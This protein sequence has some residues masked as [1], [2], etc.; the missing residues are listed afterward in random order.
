[1][2]DTKHLNRALRAQAAPCGRVYVPQVEARRTWFE[3]LVPTWSAVG[4]VGTTAGGMSEPVAFHADGCMFHAMRPR[5]FFDL[6]FWAFDRQP[7]ERAGGLE[8]RA[9]GCFGRCLKIF[10]C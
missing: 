1:M 10:G 6:R 9:R 2:I 3:E 7:T 4:R 5:S 8:R